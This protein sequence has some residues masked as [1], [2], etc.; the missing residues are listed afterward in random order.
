MHIEIVRYSTSSESTLG[1]LLIN[2]QFECYTLEDEFR[3][4]KIAGESRIPTGTYNI[5]LRTH[6]NHHS[7]Y[8]AKYGNDFHYGML[9]VMDVPGF[10]DILI[11]KGNTD[12]DTTGCLLIGDGANN[13]QT[14]AGFISNSGLAYERIYP[15]IAT[16]LIAGNTVDIEYRDQ[17]TKTPEEKITPTQKVNTERLYLRE[18]PNGIKKAIL[19][20]DSE[21]QFQKKQGE[22]SKVKLEGWV[23]NKFIL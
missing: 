16:E 11:H 8:L 10:T 13:N 4:E 9:Q 1:L 18:V 20:E 3:E 7:K 14:K 12:D 21:L 19:F 6:G 22:W 23:S 2:G 17:L 15:K 5:Q